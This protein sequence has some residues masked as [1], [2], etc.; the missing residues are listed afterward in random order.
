MPTADSQIG[1]SV[2]SSPIDQCA[3]FEGN[4]VLH[5]DREPVIENPTQA[6]WE[7]LLIE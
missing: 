5:S 3:L 1:D 4:S 7:K 2:G 6:R